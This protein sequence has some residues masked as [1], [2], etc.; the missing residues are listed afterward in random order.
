MSTLR[1]PV[2]LTMIG[3]AFVA[4]NGC[5]DR[6]PTGSALPADAS[7]PAAAP[8]GVAAVRPDRLAQLFAKALASPAFRAYVKAQLDASPFPEHKIELQ[9]FLPAASGRALRYLA[10]GSNTTAADV[11]A[12]L[13]RAIP[14]EVYLPVPAQRAAWS[15]DANVLVAT[16]LQDHD[17]PVAFDP[18][19]R[20]YLLS[21]DAPPATPVIAMV[22]VETDFQ[23]PP[24]RIQ[25]IDLDCGGSGGGSGGGGGTVTPPAGLYMRKS[26]V[27]GDFEGW[28]KGSPEY[29]VHILGQLGQTDSLKDYACA[30]EHQAGFQYYDQ[31]DAD[32]TGDVLLYTQTDLDTYK[33]QHP[34]QGV[35]VLM[36]EDDDTPCVIKTDNTSINRLFATADSVYKLYTA[37]K[38][39]KTTVGKVW[40]AAQI[41]RK[42]WTYAA[43][44]IKTNDDLVGNE[45]DATVVG[46][47]THA[48]YNWILK[49]DRN[50]TT[51]WTDLEMR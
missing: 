43:G 21:A 45:I 11:G 6:A 35:R 47:L 2:T 33:A 19:G 30:G 31:N 50:A 32:W 18:A 25:C 36:I 4:L 22:P 51:G 14:L 41:L 40:W 29:E 34:G 48:G 1:V 37:G 28:L 38:D 12:E 9:R 44:L 17:S 23:T 3:V 10:E 20:R 13:D 5:R 16:A 42:I 8:P 39:Q 49:G 24:A 7:P 46:D 26:H 15:G 27:V